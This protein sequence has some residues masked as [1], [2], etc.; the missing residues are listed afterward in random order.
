MNMTI[1]SA[2]RSSEQRSRYETLNSYIS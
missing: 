2:F 1:D